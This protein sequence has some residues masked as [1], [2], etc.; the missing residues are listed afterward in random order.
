M[1]ELHGN[2][3]WSLER[4]ISSLLRLLWLLFIND[5]RPRLGVKTPDT[6]FLLPTSG[7][8]ELPKNKAWK[9]H[10][11]KEADQENVPKAAIWLLTPFFPSDLAPDPFFSSAIWLLTPFFPQRFGSC[12]LFFLSDLAPDPFFSP[13]FL[14]PFF[15][16]D[17]FFL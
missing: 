3:L 17:P 8:T 15:I 7:S 16:P 13:F 12:P 11:F 5:L 10:F 14:T 1:I 2:R 6:F 4:V 9:S